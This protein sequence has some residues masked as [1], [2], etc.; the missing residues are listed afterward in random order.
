M[1]FSIGQNF[2]KDL[3]ESSDKTVNND[4]KAIE[5][6]YLKQKRLND[7][8]ANN[9]IPVLLKSK[10]FGGMVDLLG[11]SEPLGGHINFQR[12]GTRNAP[13]SCVNGCPNEY[14]FWGISKD[15]KP[16]IKTEIKKPKNN[17]NIVEQPNVVENFTID[18]IIDKKEY[19]SENT[20]NT[21]VIIL[22]IVIVLLIV[23]FGGYL[24][25]ER[26]KTK[27]F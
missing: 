26:N 6:T 11:N 25:F 2:F 15:N 27:I 23:G 3:L 8:W 12:C 16:E 4:K 5:L 17:N 14:D 20:S 1:T 9:D 24:F 13:G 19:F 22:I 7:F 18:D 21:I 10:E